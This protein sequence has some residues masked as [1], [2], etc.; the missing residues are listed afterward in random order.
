MRE[1]LVSRKTKETEITI[2]VNLDG[3][4]KSQIN[5]GIGFFD[6]MLCCFAKHALIDLEIKAIGDLNV[7]SHH[8]VEDVGIVLG[9]AINKALN[10]KEQIERYGFFILPMDESLVLSSLDISG[11]SYFSMDYSFQ[12]ERVGNFET[13]T[14]EEFFRALTNSAKMTLHF[15]IKRVRNNH[16]VIEAMFKSFARAFREAIK[17]N[18]QIEGIPSTKSVL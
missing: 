16:H 13:E 17:I 9:D 8:T 2:N 14:I 11:R 10:T 15:E 12:V 5:T 18:P 7:D 6:H 1:A 3:T 4:G